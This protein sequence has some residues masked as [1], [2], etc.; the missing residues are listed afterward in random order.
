M[1]FFSRIFKIGQAEA[2]SLADKLEDPIKMTE[3]GIRDLKKDLDQSLQALAEVKAAA[4]RTKR[5]LETAKSQSLS[6]EAKA[7]QLLQKAE[8][9]E[10]A[11]EDADRLA[12]EALIKKETADQD[13]ARQTGEVEMFDKNIAQLDANVAKLRSTITKYENELKTLKARARVS[14]ATK[15]LNKSMANV[16]SSGTIAMLEKMKDKVAQDEALAEAYGDVA[17]QPNSVDDEIDRALGGSSNSSA[18]LA[19]LKAK[20]KGGQ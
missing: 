18:A 3:Q 15:K 16:D 9:G 7:I 12:S 20:M 2:H 13:V 5:D 19:A 11:I 4:I 6:Y 8:K 1:G 10:L 17:N 14:D